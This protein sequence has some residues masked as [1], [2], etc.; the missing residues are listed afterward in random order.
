ML[1]DN[2]ELIETNKSATSTGGDIQ[3]TTF[4]EKA[5]TN[6]A[7]RSQGLTVSNGSSTN[8]GGSYK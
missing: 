7:T 4:E 5:D 2:V 3:V 6:T 8:T 1:V